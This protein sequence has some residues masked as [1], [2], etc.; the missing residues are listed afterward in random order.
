M[1]NLKKK[2]RGNDLELKKLFDFIET[3]ITHL[4]DG[5]KANNYQI[6]NLEEQKFLKGLY[7]LTS[8]PQLYVCN[9]SE[10]DIKNGNNFTNEIKNNYVNNNSKVILISSLIESEIAILNLNDKKEFLIDLGLKETGLTKL[11]RSGYELLDLITFFTAG[12]KE[13]RAWTINKGSTAS[14]AA[15]KIHSDFEKGFIRA[16]TTGYKEFIE[17]NGDQGSKDAGKLRIEGSDYIVQDG[18]IFN[19]RFN[20]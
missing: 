3:L 10:E 4:S 11:I 2:I 12:P 5:Q 6:R 9:V 14:K 17:F 8:K 20:V 15:G 16:E 19:F 7:L 13:T 18:D 1:V